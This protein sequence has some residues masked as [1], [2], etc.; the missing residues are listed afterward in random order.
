LQQDLF[1]TEI[2]ELVSSSIYFGELLWP[3]QQIFIA[4]PILTVY[5]GVLWIFLG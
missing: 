1:D 4:K 5:N 2:Q 3:S